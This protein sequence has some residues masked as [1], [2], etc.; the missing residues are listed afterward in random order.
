MVYFGV[1]ML[2]VVVFFCYSNVGEVLVGKGLV[3]VVRYRME[4]DQR[5][6]YYDELLV[7]EVRVQ[8]KGV[9]LYFKKEVLIYRVVDVFGVRFFFFFKVCEEIV[10]YSRIRNE[11]SN[12]K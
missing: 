3:I 6:E 9:G 10:R 5:F 2:I 7:V 1:V 11:S 4:D 8:K 12:K